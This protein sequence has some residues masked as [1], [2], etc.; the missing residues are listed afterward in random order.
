[1]YACI[2]HQEVYD[3][4]ISCCHGPISA[5]LVGVRFAFNDMSSITPKCFCLYAC[6]I[7]CSCPDIKA[8]SK[9]SKECEPPKIKKKRLSLALKDVGN[10]SGPGCFQLVIKE[11]EEDLEKGFIPENTQ[12]ATQWAL[13]VFCDWKTQEQT[14]G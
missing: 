11:A 13:K 4:H 9:C 7:K 14:L 6:D 10:C 8:C 5:H 1:M 12:H 2:T 3:S